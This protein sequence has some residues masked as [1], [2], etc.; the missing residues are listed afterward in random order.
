M[1]QERSTH[2][3]Q[4]VLDAVKARHDHPTA[5]EIYL[6]VRAQDGR[7]SRGTVYRNLGFLAGKGAILQ[8]KVPAADRFDCRLDFHYHL[9]CTACGAVSDAPLVYH[10]E[11]DDELSRETGY[12]IARHRT[13]FEG[14]C[15]AC[16][17]RLLAQQGRAVPAGE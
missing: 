15:P 11:L 16:R 14:L 7:I 12:A 1:K 5:D 17:R 2:Q 4:L 6:D 9:L 3:R 8:V 13:V 10:A